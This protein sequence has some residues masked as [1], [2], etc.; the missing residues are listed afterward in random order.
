VFKILQYSE[1]ESNCVRKVTEG[2]LRTV[3]CRRS[4][5]E[6]GYVLLVVGSPNDVRVYVLLVVVCYNSTV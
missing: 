3:G 2:W 5:D 1:M 4:N 6:R